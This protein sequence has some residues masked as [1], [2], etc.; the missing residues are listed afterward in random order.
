MRWRH[1]LTGGRGHDGQPTES[2]S[3]TLYLAI[4]GLVSQR[5]KTPLIYWCR[6]PAEES[7]SMPRYWIV[8]GEYADTSFRRIAGGGKEERIGPFDSYGAAKTEW[9][10]RAW[11]SVDNAHVRYRIVKEG[12]ARAKAGKKA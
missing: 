10:Q 11:A 8:G 9:Q 7:L 3:P 1:C 2:E 12:E 5:S 4:F 6:L